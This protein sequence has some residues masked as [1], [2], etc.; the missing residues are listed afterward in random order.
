MECAILPLLNANVLL[1]ISRP[2][3]DHELKDIFLEAIREPLRTTLTVF[4]FWNQSIEQVID[5]AIAMGQNPKNGRSMH[6]SAL[7]HTLPTLEELQFRQAVQC[8]FCLNTRHSIIE[9]SL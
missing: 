9:C 7:H 8:T 1:E 6:M 4:D 3:R 2:I 5:K